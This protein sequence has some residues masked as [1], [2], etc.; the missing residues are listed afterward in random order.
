MRGRRRRKIPAQNSFEPRR[1]LPHALIKQVKNITTDTDAPLS[2]QFVVY[3]VAMLC[4][5]H[6][7]TCASKI[8][9][10]RVKSGHV[11]FVHMHEVAWLHRGAIE[12]GPL[13]Q[14]DQ[15]L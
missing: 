11:A 13:K 14:V 5:E 10:I 3:I 12:M 4:D 1:A 7:P 9:P 15:G 8:Q 2:G 6:V